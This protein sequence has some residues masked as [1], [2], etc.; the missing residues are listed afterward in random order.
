LREF[1]RPALLR[2][3]GFSVK[4][5]YFTARDDAIPN[6]GGFEN[7]N[8]KKRRRP[9]ANVETKMSYPTHEYVL[10]YV[11]KALEDFNNAKSSFIPEIMTRRATLS[12][13][14]QPDFCDLLVSYNHSY[15]T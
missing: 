7:A 6:S 2:E 1:Y 9:S 4:T 14:G 8:K 10:P 12:Q 13:V 5:P 11:S 15:I 3:D